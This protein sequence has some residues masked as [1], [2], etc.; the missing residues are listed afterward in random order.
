MCTTWYHFGLSAVAFCL[1]D[2]LEVT[3]AVWKLAFALALSP[4]VP[5]R[6]M[7]KTFLDV[8]V[9]LP[10]LSSHGRIVSPVLFAEGDR[11]RTSARSLRLTSLP[12]FFASQKLHNRI[13]RGAR[14]RVVEDGR[15]VTLQAC[16]DAV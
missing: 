1:R 5:T 8:L 2:P 10:P 16:R 3:E 15:E 9:R 12:C 14:A 13:K 7:G 6:D 4:P 11:P